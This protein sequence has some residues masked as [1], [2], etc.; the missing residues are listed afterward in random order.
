MNAKSSPKIV[1][2]MPSLLLMCSA[3]GVNS[4]SPSSFM[5]LIAMWPASWVMP[6]ELVDEVHMPG[7]AAELAVRDRAQADLF[8]LADRLADRVVLDRAQRGGVD[9]AGRVLLARLVQRAAA[10]AGCR[11]GRP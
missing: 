6:V 4:I 5:N 10:A 7:A 3:A 2:E 1:F 11:R 9:V 8:L